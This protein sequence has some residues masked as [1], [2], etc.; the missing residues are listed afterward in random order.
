MVQEI[1][2]TLY[3]KE[4]VIFENRSANYDKNILELIFLML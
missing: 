1:A 2:F 3:Q 4:E